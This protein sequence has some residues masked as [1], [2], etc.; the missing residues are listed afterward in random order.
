[1]SNK[2]NLYDPGVR[3]IYDHYENIKERYW[4]VKLAF[5]PD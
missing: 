4:R 2:C 3:I 5:G 1:M